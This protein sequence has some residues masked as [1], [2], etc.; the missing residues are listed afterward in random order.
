MLELIYLWVSFYIGSWVLSSL[1]WRQKTYDWGLWVLSIKSRRDGESSTNR[2]SHWEIL[3]RFVLLRIV[4]IKI[5]Q[6]FKYPTV[7][8]PLSFF[9]VL[10][11]IMAAERAS[12]D[13]WPLDTACP[14]PLFSDG[15]KPKSEEGGSCQESCN[16]GREKS[17]RDSTW[18]ISRTQVS[19]FS[20]PL[21]GDC[22]QGNRVSG[23]YGIQKGEQEERGEPMTDLATLTPM[24]I[25]SAMNGLLDNRGDSDSLLTCRFPSCSYT[26]DLNVRLC[27]HEVNK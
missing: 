15:Y 3:S 13:D 17:L 12:T 14:S 6:H 4:S 23:K 19:W 24:S 2:M 27:R 25:Y 22:C 21:S 5:D 9:S 18:L 26:T 16:R 11:L 10:T 7:D 8:M 1:I 20:V